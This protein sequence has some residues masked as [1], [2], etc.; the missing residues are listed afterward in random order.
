MINR[1]IQAIEAII[2][3]KH[4]KQTIC[5]LSISACGKEGKYKIQGNLEYGNEQHEDIT[6]EYKNNLYFNS[7]LVS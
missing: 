6:C 1:C 3:C 7:K 2:S 4:F 5:F